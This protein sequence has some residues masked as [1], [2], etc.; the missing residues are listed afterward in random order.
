[1]LPWLSNED[2]KDLLGASATITTVLQFLTGSL[3]CYN[4]L[5]KKST[6][7][8]IFIPLASIT[9]SM[10]LFLDKFPAFHQRSTFLLVMAPIWSP[11]KRKHCRSG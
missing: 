10:F 7:E 2:L 9:T 1:M 4:Y 3:I 6:G 5:K 8:V 11:H